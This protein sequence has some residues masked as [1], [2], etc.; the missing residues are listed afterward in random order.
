M[1]RKLTTKKVNRGHISQTSKWGSCNE[2]K[3]KPIKK[4]IRMGRGMEKQKR[5]NT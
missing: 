1:F 4:N 3:Q 5:Q 2:N